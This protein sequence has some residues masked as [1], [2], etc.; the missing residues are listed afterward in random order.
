M[1]RM[2]AVT[3]ARVT[4]MGS[5]T[6]TRHHHSLLSNNS[7]NNNFPAAVQ[8]RLMASSLSK[9]DIESRVLAVCKA[10]DRITAD[11]VLHSTNAYIIIH[12]RG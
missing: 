12:C 7:N 2:A 5:W 11:K 9:S 1:M 8:V 4:S 3:S 6:Q 10:F